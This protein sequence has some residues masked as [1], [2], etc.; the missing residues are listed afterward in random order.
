MTGTEHRIRYETELVRRIEMTRA[1]CV[2][3]NYASVRWTLPA[4][5]KLSGAAHVYAMTF[6]QPA[7]R[8]SIEAP[9][10]PV[11]TITPVTLT[12]CYLLEDSIPCDCLSGCTGC[13]GCVCCC[14]CER[15]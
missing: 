15:G 1:V 10:S 5:A 4:R 2:C 13:T 9:E 3:G 6:L 12:R 14:I 11:E 8:T 7:V